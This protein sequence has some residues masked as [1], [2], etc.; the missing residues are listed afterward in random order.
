MR[1]VL[2]GVTILCFAA[3]YAVALALELICL[4]RPEAVRRWVI[5][6]IAA[7]GF[8]AHTI[9]VIR[10]GVP[11]RGELSALLTLSWILAIFYLIGSVHHRRQAWGVFA[12][13]VV[14]ILVLAAW[15]LPESETGTTLAATESSAPI[16]VGL[17][18]TLMLMG[19]VGL[20]V[21][22]VASIM[23]LVQ[24][25]RLKH[26]LPPGKGLRLLSLERLEAMN[27][28]AIDLAFPLFTAG[29]ALG[30]IL[31]AG[32]SRPLTIGDPKVITTAL[33]WLM[34]AV[35]WYLRHGLHLRG[36]K[37]AWWTVVAFVLLVWAFVVHHFDAGV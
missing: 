22:F 3:S 13:P 9:F 35:L 36:R 2:K 1:I 31:L 33:L 30:F 7:L 4:L 32:T 11:L 10:H 14:L 27:R 19:A 17:H 12:L 23:L 5:T 26:K 8:V 29:L 16:W 24:S 20:C 21:A 37:V 6:A 25:A 34:F 18:I 28:R 15:L